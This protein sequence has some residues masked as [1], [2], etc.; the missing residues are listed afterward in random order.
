MTTIMN[1]IV[2]IAIMEQMQNIN[3]FM[4]S[5]IRTDTTYYIGNAF[6]FDC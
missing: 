2:M 1:L 6:D 3:D 5:E 4:Q